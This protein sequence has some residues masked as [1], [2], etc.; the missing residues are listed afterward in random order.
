MSMSPEGM[1]DGEKVARAYEVYRLERVLA[2]GERAERTRVVLAI[3]AR[4]RL[5]VQAA[6]WPK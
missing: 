5:A 6:Q 3:V 2:D 4:W 1:R